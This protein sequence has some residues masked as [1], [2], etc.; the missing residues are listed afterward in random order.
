VYRRLILL[1]KLW[2]GISP[3]GSEVPTSVWNLPYVVWIGYADACDQY[4]DD[5]RKEASRG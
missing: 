2:P 1:T 3:H 5:M 4:E